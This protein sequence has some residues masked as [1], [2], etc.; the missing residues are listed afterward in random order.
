MSFDLADF[1]Y[2][3]STIDDFLS[4]SEPQCLIDIAT[5]Y[6]DE[7]EI[8]DEESEVNEIEFMSLT[9]PL[10]NGKIILKIYDSFGTFCYLD[11]N[12]EVIKCINFNDADVVETGGSFKKALKQIR[13]IDRE[14]I[15]KSRIN[16][17]P[18][19]RTSFGLAEVN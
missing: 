14:S 15:N 2:I 1:R 8:E 10:K 4:M 5:G 13:N 3:V 7:A 19:D 6:D 12:G 9:F 16:N 17:T 18:I 11:S